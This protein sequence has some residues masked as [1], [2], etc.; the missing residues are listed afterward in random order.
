MIKISEILALEKCLLDP[1]VRRSASDVNQL[2]SDGFWEIGASGRYFT[3]Q[4]ILE[5]LNSSPDNHERRLLHPKLYIIGETLCLLKY[6]CRRCLPDN[7]FVNSSRSSIWRM[8][9]SKW[10]M[11]FHHG[12]LIQ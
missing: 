4:D 5:E 11:I 8:E 10:K 1:L 7:T 9:T 12:I 3:K 2:L 6:Q